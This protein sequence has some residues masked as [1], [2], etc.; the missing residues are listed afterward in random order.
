MEINYWDC[1]YKGDAEEVELSANNWE[2]FYRC[3]HPDGH[4]LC[5]LDNKYA[6]K[7]APCSLISE[8]DLSES[9][10]KECAGQKVHG[11]Y[12]RKITMSPKIVEPLID[13]PF[14]FHLEMK[15]T[16]IAF[17]YDREGTRQLAFTNIPGQEA[18]IED[19]VLRVDIAIPFLDSEAETVI[20]M[21]YGEG[22]QGRYMKTSEFWKALGYACSP[23][24]DGRSE[25]NDGTA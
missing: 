25:G 19:G 23:G 7:K 22:V 20:W 4:N 11:Q 12:V 3:G 5:P 6:D 8:N 21:T 9:G 1:P 14:R 16:G 15:D 10:L 13:F 2:C 18:L 24:I 17:S